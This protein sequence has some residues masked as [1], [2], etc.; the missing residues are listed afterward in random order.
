MTYPYDP[1]TALELFHADHR[2]DMK[3][4]R[5]PGRAKSGRRSV[6]SGRRWTIIGAAVAVTM[7]ATAGIPANSASTGSPSGSSSTCDQGG[8]YRTGCQL[9][10]GRPDGWYDATQPT[11]APVMSTGSG[12][13]NFK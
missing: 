12:F 3:E 6:G 4:A 1:N 10:A 5:L 9:V 2:R 13:L 11:A 7:F 8:N